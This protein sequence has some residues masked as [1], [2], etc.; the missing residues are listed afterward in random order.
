MSPGAA[1]KGCSGASQ[2][3]PTA[4]RNPSRWRARGRPRRSSPRRRC[5]SLHRA[6]R[7]P[8]ATVVHMAA[9]GRYRRASSAEVSGAGSAPRRWRPPPAPR[10]GRRSAASAPND[11]PAPPRVRGSGGTDTVGHVEQGTGF[12]G[13][14]Y[15]RERIAFCRPMPGRGRVRDSTPRTPRRACP[16][17]GGIRNSCRQGRRFIMNKTEEPS[18]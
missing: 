13:Q 16:L 12:F 11:A 15:D 9:E 5:T 14:R 1:G 18:R 4:P 7:S 3:S 2:Y 10:A 8:A 6:R 17:K